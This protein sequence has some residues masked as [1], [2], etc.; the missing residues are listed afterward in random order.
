[1]AEPLITPTTNAGD[2]D[3]GTNAATRTFIQTQSTSDY[4]TGFEGYVRQEPRFALGAT[5]AEDEQTRLALAAEVARRSGN[6]SEAVAPT[7]AGVGATDDSV[8]VNNTGG[9][10]AYGGATQEEQD[11][12]IKAQQGT[13]AGAAGTNT[14]KQIVP[15]G[16]ILDRFASYTYRASVYLMTS[17]QY[18]QLIRSQKKSINGYNLL[19]Q[20]GGAPKNV[21]GVGVGQP[22]AQTFFENDGSASTTGYNAGRNP[23]FPLDFYIDSITIKNLNQGQATG[24]SH[25]ATE[26]KFTVIEPMGITLLDRIYQAVQDQAPKEQGT[27]KIN[28]TTAQYLMVLRWYGYDI[29]GNLIKGGPTLSDP[30]AV[31]EKFIPFAIN[32]INW[33]ANSKLVNYDFDCTPIDQY[34][35]GGSRRGAV[36]YNMQLSG[37]TVADVLGGTVSTQTPTAAAPGVSTTSST[38]DQSD[39][40][41]K[42]LQAANAAA[43]PPKANA[44]GNPDPAVKVGLMGAMNEHVNQLTTG[45]RPLYQVADQYEIVF[46]GAAKQLI[47][48]ATIVLPGEKKEANQTPMGSAQTKDAKSASPNTDQKNVTQKIIPVVAGQSI[49][50]IIDKVIRNSSYITSQQLTQINPFGGPTDLDGGGEQPNPEAAN[51]P[52]NWFRINFEA[53][54]IKPDNLRNDYAYKIRYIISVYKIDKYDSKYFPVGTFRGVH[55]SYPWWFTGKNTAVLEYQET[56][57]TAYNMLVSGSD[58]QDSGS[59]TLRKQIAATMQDIV[60]YTYGPNSGESMQG[61]K[62][63]GNEASA[64][65]A[66]SLY[67][68]ADLANSTLKIIGDPAWI[69]Q[70]SLSG[71]VTAADLEI[72][73]FLPDGTINFDGEQ[74]LYEVTWNRPDDYDLATGMAAPTSKKNKTK[75]RVYLATTVT[76][77]FKQGKFEQSIS[78][79]LFNLPKPD[80]SNKAPDA[81]L[82]IPTNERDERGRATTGFD[83]RVA[84]TQSSMPTAPQVNVNP[85]NNSPQTLNTSAPGPNDGASPAP[86]PQSAT[87][88]SGENLDVGDPF[89]PPGALSGRITA[90][91]LDNSPSTPQIISRDY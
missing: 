33:S 78:G 19:F 79:T 54:P 5:S 16:N 42:R 4:E 45:A 71:G 80:G 83:S 23:A 11:A 70:G 40:E 61:S 77:E 12:I 6:S 68:G 87:S 20:S 67:G 88:G 59:E 50:Q 25:S 81:S 75:S 51:K 8:G 85:S 72:G 76:S 60:I 31:V 91:G 24:I 84:A 37:S 29:D 44:A 90:D 35:A 1:M 3:Q 63:R 57:N 48:D 14:R 36:P 82:P 32:S 86:P 69:Q 65:M 41:T 7:S 10:S 66:D 46:V 18:Q 62:D 26:L 47:G 38:T 53:I 17:D 27:G 64:N 74:I 49:V 56:L 52:V 15:R 34:V 9:D 13:V 22:P 2:G 43:A 89:V 21:G 30:N 55:K 58:T 28:Y 73:S 39:A